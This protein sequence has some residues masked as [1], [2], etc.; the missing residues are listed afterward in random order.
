MLARF[1]TVSEKALHEVTAQVLVNKG[2]KLGVLGR[3]DEPIAGY[4]RSGSSAMHTVWFRQQVEALFT[5]GRSMA[6]LSATC[7]RLPF[8]PTF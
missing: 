7:R 1:G 4:T 3:G 8:M 5:K 2:G 6:S